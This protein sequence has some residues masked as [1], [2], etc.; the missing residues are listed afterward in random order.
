MK[1]SNFPLFD[2]RRRIGLGAAR[3]GY[4]R[5]V[6]LVLVWISGLHVLGSDGL[7][8]VQLQGPNY[9]RRGENLKL[10]CNY[11]TESES[12]Y[13]LKWY[14]ESE[15]F[16]R[17]IPKEVPAQQVF[18]LSG[19]VVDMNSSDDHNVI[20]QN[21]SR[22]TGGKFKC[23]VSAEGS[24]QTK[25]DAKNI[26]TVAV[27]YD[28][29]K[30]FLSKLSYHPG[31]IGE[32]NCT[33]EKTFPPANISW[34]IN[35]KQVAVRQFLTRTTEDPSDATLTSTFSTLIFNVSNSYSPMFIKCIG[36]LYDLYME[37]T[38]IKIQPRAPSYSSFGGVPDPLRGASNSTDSRGSASRE[39]HL[40]T[41]LLSAQPFLLLSLQARL[42]GGGGWRHI[43]S[44]SSGIR[45]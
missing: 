29:P 35:D 18:P 45:I 21:A 9:V 13:A 32:A 39:S 17:Y 10:R 30:L 34:L 4:N 28:A 14:R 33:L 41:L 44:S 36:E 11:D 16:Y 22:L 5:A 23:V 38:V 42:L 20:L 43:P 37:T 24:F 26:S 6:L 12:L 25:L 40:S 27:G 31:E 3:L 19:I 1:S 15:E 8:D 7:K 2:E